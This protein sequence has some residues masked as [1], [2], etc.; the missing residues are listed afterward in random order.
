MGRVTFQGRPPCGQAA[1][2]YAY[3]FDGDGDNDVLSSS[4][5]ARHLVA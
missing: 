4:P 5:H 2:M 3:D 1:Q